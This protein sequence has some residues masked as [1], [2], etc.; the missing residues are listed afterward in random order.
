MH[1]FVAM[2]LHL[3]SVGE[4]RLAYIAPISASDPVHSLALSSADSAA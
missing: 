3:R 4:T 2:R 1:S